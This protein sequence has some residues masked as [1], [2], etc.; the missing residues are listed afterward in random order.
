M[1]NDLKPSKR[2]QHIYAI[3]RYEAD[4]DP[5]VPIEFRITV[6][7]VVVD[8]RHADAEVRQLNDLNRDKNSYYFSQV[9]RLEDVPIEVQAV[10]NSQGASQTFYPTDH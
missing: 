6:K 9:T 7:K 10:T 5:D 8:P 2:Y 1:S 3:V 4:A